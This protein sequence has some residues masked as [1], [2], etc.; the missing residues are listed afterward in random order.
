MRSQVT[1]AHG[2]TVDH[3]RHGSGPGLVFIAG[4]GMW[5][6]IDEVTGPTAE[7]AAARGITTIEYDRL[8]RGE[9]RVD[10]TID[11]GRELDAVAALIA[12]AG[13]RAVLCGH[14]SGC[15]IALAA[16]ARGLPVDG[17]ALWEAPMDPATPGVTE[18]VDEVGRRIAADDLEGAL[19]WYMK[20]MPPEFL[21]GAKASPVWPAMVA[22]AGSLRPDGESLAWAM[23]APH[24]ELLGGLAIP[25]QV[26][27][28]VQTFPEMGAAAESIVAAVPGATQ[29]E[30]PGAMHSWE[31]EAMA[32]ELAR[33]TR[34]AA[35]RAATAG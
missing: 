23:S 13:G 18:W 29:R 33:F 1:T 14:S 15:S 6:A 5:R 25:V 2:D 7:L 4:A 17:L 34:A 30:M 28:G 12:A 19:T 11:L 9:N 35:S 3:D 10:G 27:Y 24:A 21:E 8:G 26:M 22:Q 20:D 16:A 32:A 31:P